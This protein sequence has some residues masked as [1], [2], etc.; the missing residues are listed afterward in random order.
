VTGFRLS[1]LVVT[2]ENQEPASVDFKPGLNV[3]SGGSD[4]GKTWLFQCLSYMLGGSEMPPDIKEAKPYN[5]AWLEIATY[6]GISYTLKRPLVGGDALVFSN[7]YDDIKQG[8]KSQVLKRKKPSKKAPQNISMFFQELSGFP[9]AKIVA[10]KDNKK[11]SLTFRTLRSLFLAGEE[12]IIQKYSPVMVDAFSRGSKAWAILKLVLTGQDDSAVETSTSKELLKAGNEGQI[13]LI[14]K[15]ISAVKDELTALPEIQLAELD[16]VTRT[17]D[18]SLFRA[19]RQL[20]DYDDSRRAIMSSIAEKDAKVITLTELQSRFNILQAHYQSDIDRLSF[21]AEGALLF[22]EL[23]F[24]EC[25]YCLTP[26]SNHALRKACDKNEIPASLIQQACQRERGKA[27]RQLEELQTAL[28][29]VAEERHSLEASVKEL[30][31]QYDGVIS[32]INEGLTPQIQGLRQELD[33]LTSQRSQAVEQEL[34]QKRLAQYQELRD[35]FTKTTSKS[36]D[37]QVARVL[38][39][40]ALKSF[41]SEVEKLL[42]DWGVNF[43]SPVTFNENTQVL[44][45]ILGGEPRANTGKGTRAIT[46][47][48]FMLGVLKHCESKNLPHS[49]LVILDSPLTTFEDGEKITKGDE[50]SEEV[51]HN[52]FNMI[53]KYFINNQVVIIENK[54]PPE[55]LIKSIHYIKFTKNLNKGRYGFFP[56]RPI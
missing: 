15:L 53:A 24:V 28:N 56:I 2:G 19:L 31:E 20:D 26:L 50:V 35:S 9:E 37:S 10:N 11:E 40:D 49:R 34:L 32:T 41:C 18:L 21:L 4:T 54:I 47:S 22:D 12:E 23:Q 8:E 17:I 52:F 7:K 39:A 48:S 45:I 1:K 36:A 5:F 16:V 13:K 42:Q 55:E 25:P 38:D 44:D 43:S 29:T 27:V 14:D 51:Q 30:T 6:D 33:N 3:I 46:Y